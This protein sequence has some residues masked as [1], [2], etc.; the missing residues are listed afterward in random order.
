M[1][2]PLRSPAARRIVLPLVRCM[3]KGP[4]AAR[5]TRR[6]DQG[7]PVAPV[8]SDADMSIVAPIA[9]SLGTA[10]AEPDGGM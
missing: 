1:Q 5:R 4:A 8:A 10:G 6:T 3:L 7:T 2:Q 9:A